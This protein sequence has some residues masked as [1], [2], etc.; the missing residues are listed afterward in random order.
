MVTSISSQLI[1]L[2]QL[3]AKTGRLL[4][5]VGPNFSLIYNE[6]KLYI[7]INLNIPL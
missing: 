3:I 5:I 1:L 2:H 4:E 7:P 6:N